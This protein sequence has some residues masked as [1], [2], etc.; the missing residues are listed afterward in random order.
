MECRNLKK[1]T[2]IDDDDAA[3]AVFLA[4]NSIVADASSWRE[5][6]RDG[7][8]FVKKINGFAVKMEEYRKMANANA[9][10]FRSRF[11]TKHR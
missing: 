2:R 5:R 3:G 1:V 9:V 4:V 6:W 7:G 10:K 8:V 11:E